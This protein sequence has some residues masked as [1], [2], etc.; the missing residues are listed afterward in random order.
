M[1]MQNFVNYWEYNTTAATTSLT[2]QINDWIW[3]EGPY[4]GNAAI[5]NSA[6]IFTLLDNAVV[7]LPV[8]LDSSYM[9]STI[10]VN[11]GYQGE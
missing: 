2:I 7:S 1:V 10:N 3:C 6:D 5:S 4:I 8:T 9:T 11:L